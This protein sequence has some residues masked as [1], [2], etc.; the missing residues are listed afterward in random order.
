MTLATDGIYPRC[1]C[2]YIPEPLAD[3]QNTHDK[4]SAAGDG[5]NGDE[6]SAAGDGGDGLHK[7][8]KPHRKKKSEMTP[9][10]INLFNR[11]K[12]ERKKLR[13]AELEAAG[14]D[15]RQSKHDFALRFPAPK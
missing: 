15:T 8:G 14:H 5:G 4:E 1:H 13:K 11:Q 9:E 12:K 7:G 6:E 10:E 2:C 3:L